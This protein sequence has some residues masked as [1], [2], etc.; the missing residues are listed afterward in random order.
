MYIS[1]YMAII[2]GS[3]HCPLDR[4]GAY[5]LRTGA[6]VGHQSSLCRRLSEKD[7]GSPICCGGCSYVPF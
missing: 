5:N 7:E 3:G 1:K 2:A 4:S 6:L